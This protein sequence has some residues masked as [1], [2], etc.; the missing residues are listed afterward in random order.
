MPRDTGKLYTIL[1]AVGADGAGNAIYVADYRNIIIEV[2]FVGATCTLKFAGGIQDSAPAIA[3]AQS[4]ANPWDYIEVID[5]Q[6]GNS[7]DGD[8]GIAASAATDVRLFEINT[9]G[10]TH[11]NAIVSSW[12]AGAITAKV[13]L[14][15][16]EQ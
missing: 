6:N 11:I 5:L 12:S 16:S 10:L 14:F 15:A 8:T 3:S 7:I 2:V 13:R 9:N 1:D 4:L